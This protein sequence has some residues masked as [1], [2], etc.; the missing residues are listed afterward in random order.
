M[1]NPVSEWL[2]KAEYAVEFRYPGESAT[3]ESAIEAVAIMKRSRVEI[4]KVLML[5]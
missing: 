1:G 2:E 5:A 4:R 3:I